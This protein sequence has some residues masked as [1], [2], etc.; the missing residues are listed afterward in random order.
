MVVVLL[1]GD[2]YMILYH[3]SEK[4]IEKPMYGKGN[5]RN[6]YGRGFYCTESEE[7]A[8]EW[9]CSNNRNG[10]A[11]KYEFDIEGLEVLYL[12]SDEYTLLNWLAILT[13]NRTYWENSTVSEMAKKYIATYFEIDISKYDVVV[14]YRA[15]DS[16]FSFAQDFVAGAIS[17]HQLGNAMKLGK[18]GEQIVLV[19]EKAFGKIH[20]VSSNAADASIYYKRKKERDRSARKAYRNTRSEEISPDEIFIVDIIRE[21][22]KQDDTRL[23]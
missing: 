14:G 7:L 6:D 9:A 13:K 15:D 5:L 4:I 19:S 21:G 10:F 8:K 16:Y 17:Y 1:F 23:R 12:N 22:M 20:Y 3:G 2:D 11:N 18:L